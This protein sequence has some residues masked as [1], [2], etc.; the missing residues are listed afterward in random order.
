MYGL[1]IVC[2]WFVYR[3]FSPNP[4]K[5]TL[6]AG[7]CR[8]PIMFIKPDIHAVWTVIFGDGLA[9]SDYSNILIWKNK[10]G[11]II[12]RSDPLL[13]LGGGTLPRFNGLF[14][15]R[16]ANQGHE[17]YNKFPH[18]VPHS[19]FRHHHHQWLKPYV[20]WRILPAKNREN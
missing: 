20:L 18:D 14:A 2:A 17:K 10:I 16:N 13:K 12:D 3:V 11:W 1:C 7:D 19:Y 5:L 6:S 4:P 9:G 15:S 8:D